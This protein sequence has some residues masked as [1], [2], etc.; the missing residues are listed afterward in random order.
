LTRNEQDLVTEYC[1]AAAGNIRVIGNG[2]DVPAAPALEPGDDG[3]PV[4]LFTGRF[5]DR[6]GVRDL[7]AAIPAVLAAQPRTFSRVNQPVA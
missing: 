1:P 4:V 5:V 3:D 2:I 6:K 7:L